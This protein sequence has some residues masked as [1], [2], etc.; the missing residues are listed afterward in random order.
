M[1]NLEGFIFINTAKLLNVLLI[2]KSTLVA[3]QKSY[4]S[5]TVTYFL[6]N[7]VVITDKLYISCIYRKLISLS[8]FAC[9]HQ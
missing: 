4:Q 1:I 7:S 5:S 3:L 2:D 8:P 6:S 9:F